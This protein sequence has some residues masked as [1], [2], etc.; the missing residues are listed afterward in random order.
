VSLFDQ[1]VASINWLFLLCKIKYGITLLTMLELMNAEQPPEVN[2]STR[3][4][5]WMRW[6]TDDI[7]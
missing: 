2:N 6:N 1:R 7:V 5:E 4:L 3:I